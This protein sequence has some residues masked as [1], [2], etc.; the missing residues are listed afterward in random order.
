MTPLPVLHPGGFGLYNTA[1]TSTGKMIEVSDRIAVH[2]L[3]Q[4]MQWSYP[5]RFN[6]VHGSIKAPPPEPGMLVG[7]LHVIGRGTLPN[8]G[9]FFAVSNNKGEVYLFTT[10]DSGSPGCFATIAMA[11]DSIFRK[12]NAG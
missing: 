3:Q 2:D 8:V 1:M 4:G 10:D 6:G 5:D 11:R 12:R 7:T 9:E